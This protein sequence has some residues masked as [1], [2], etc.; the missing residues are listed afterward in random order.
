MKE[1]SI[2]LVS[3]LLN[4]LGQISG[5]TLPRAS[6]F[7]IRHPNGTYVDVDGPAYTEINNQPWI[8]AAPDDASSIKLE[9]WP[10]T[11][12]SGE[13]VTVLWQGVKDPQEKDYIAYYCPF[14]DAVPRHYIDYFYVGYA[15]GWQKGYGHYQVRVYNMRQSCV[16]KYYRRTPKANVLSATSNKLDFADGGPEA[17]THGHIAMTNDPTQMRVMWVSGE[18]THP[19]V[20]NYG[21]TKDLEMKENAYI[22]H[23]YT[24]DMMC[25][26]PAST[27]KFW[28]PGITYDVL[29][30]NLKPNTFYYYSFGTEKYMSH[31][32]NFTTPLPKGD[33]TPYKFIIYGDMGTLSVDYPRP[34]TT[35]QLVHKEVTNGARFVAHIGDISYAEGWAYYWDIW[36]PLIEPYATLVPYMVTIGNHEYDHTSG[37]RGRDPSG[38]DTDAG[39]KPSW[40]PGTYDSG[41]E[42]AVP[43]FHRYHMPENGNSMFW[44][45]YDYGMLH[46]VMFSCEHDFT[47][48]SEQYKWL[49]NDLKKVDRK[50]T[51]WLMV[52]AH[53]PMYTSEQYDTDIRTGKHMQEHLEPLFYKHRVDVAY[54]AHQH[55]HER[56]CKMYKKKCVEDGIMHVIIGNAGRSLDT[57][58][59]NKESWS[60]ARVREYGFGRVT[61]ANATSMLF[62]MI[63]NR[64]YNVRSSVWLHKEV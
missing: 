41:G 39:W 20:V 7:G 61:L 31:V 43:M 56:S 14:Y 6:F 55:T 38:V 8:N 51:P 42:C 33:H 13:L 54:W 47:V 1:F 59:Y 36:G 27:T 40:F 37:G 22:I 23:T 57:H 15:T 10:S 25:H 64:H 21:T 18:V 2:L 45:S 30:T 3:V 48:G 58:G 49:E 16:F 53:R 12:K 63:G 29:L 28:H 19:P 52:G 26:A 44:Y 50:K 34:F 46:M 35:A 60:V 62:E 32:A 9:V 5:S 11:V 17:P 24:K 4:Y